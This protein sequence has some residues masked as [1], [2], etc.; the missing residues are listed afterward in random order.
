MC[1]TECLPDVFSDLIEEALREA[2]RGL[3]PAR[4]GPPAEKFDALVNEGEEVSVGVCAV[5]VE[6][7]Q[8]RAFLKKH[9]CENAESRLVLCG[10]NQ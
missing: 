3:L 1:M 5:L 6:E 10:G 9:L 2:W 7:I 8:N 4:T